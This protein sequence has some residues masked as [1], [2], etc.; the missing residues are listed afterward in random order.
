MNYYACVYNC[1]MII[2]WNFKYMVNIKTILG[3]K[4]VNAFVGYKEM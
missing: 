1:D 3:V 2:S 4:S